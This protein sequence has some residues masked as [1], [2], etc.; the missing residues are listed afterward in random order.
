MKIYAVT[1]G[2]YSDYHICAV[3]DDEKKAELYCAVREEKDFLDNKCYVFGDEY[4]I[5]EFDTDDNNI[6][7]TVYYGVRA[8]IYEGVEDHFNDYTAFRFVSKIFDSVTETVR[9]CR[10]GMKKK[11]CKIYAYAIDESTY[12]DLKNDAFAIRDYIK[13]RMNNDQL[14]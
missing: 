13:G 11:A 2:E 12:N 8:V 10:C 4:M 9:Y 1:E 7:G 3:F 14:S 5:E 6:E